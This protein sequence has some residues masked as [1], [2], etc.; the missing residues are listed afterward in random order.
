MKR[1]GGK[2][3]TGPERVIP[4]EGASITASRVITLLARV[5]LVPLAVFAA[6]GCGSSGSTARSPAPAAIPR[7]PTVDVS[8]TGV[9]EVLVDSGG[10]TLYLFKNDR[11]TK[12]TCTGPCAGAWP[13]LHPK[14]K[15]TAGGDAK[16]SLLAVVP[17]PDGTRQ[18]AYNGHPLYLFQGDVKP[19]DANGQGTKSWGGLWY[20]LTPAG[21]RVTKK[22]RRGSRSGGGY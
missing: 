20:A 9:G 22:P 8:T 12:S 6:A 17:R 4:T 10:R 7:Q 21:N 19:G 5:A 14:G 16:A 2:C 15:P 1:A 13:P 18:I 3:K 11:G